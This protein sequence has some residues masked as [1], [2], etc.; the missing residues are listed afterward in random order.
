MVR[1]IVAAMAVIALIL[2]SLVG[3]GPAPPEAEF[4]ADSTTGYAPEG[5]QFTD[6]SQ[7]NVSTWQ[8]DFDNDGVVDSTLQNPKY[9]YSNPGNYTVSLTVVGPDGNDTEVKVDYLLFTSCP[10]FADFIADP[11]EMSG[12]NS[13]QFTDLSV[14]DASTG[15]VISWAWDFNSDGRIDSDEQNP[16]YTYTRNGLYSVTLTVITPECEDTLTRHEY[17]RITGCSG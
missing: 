9:T 2:G 17:I 6:L 15:N 8:W 14:T 11:T 3:C 12:R 4:T 13:I 16:T 7:G 1:I 10:R 5:V